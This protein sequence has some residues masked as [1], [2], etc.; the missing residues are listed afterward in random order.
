[1]APG[2]LVSKRLMSGKPAKWKFSDAQ[3]KEWS[4]KEAE[5]L[6]DPKLIK[7]ARGGGSSPGTFA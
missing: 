2:A 4:T 1:M 5:M 7:W 3:K 6:Q